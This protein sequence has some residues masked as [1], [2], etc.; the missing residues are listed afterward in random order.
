MTAVFFCN[1]GVER[2]GREDNYTYIPEHVVSYC[3]S[4]TGKYPELN[5]ALQME[6]NIHAFN[7]FPRKVCQ[8]A[9][10]NR[11]PGNKMD[12]SGIYEKGH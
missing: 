12:N 7:R 11:G 6:K 10:G 5:I 9:L 4:E 2:I 3:V 1:G 8:K